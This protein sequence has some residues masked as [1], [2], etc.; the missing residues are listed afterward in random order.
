[1]STGTPSTNAIA[2]VKASNKFVVTGIP[3]Y[4]PAAAVTTTT[5]KELGLKLLRSH[6]QQKDGNGTNLGAVPVNNP[7]KGGDMGGAIIPTV[8][9]VTT[10][11]QTQLIQSSNSDSSSLGPQIRP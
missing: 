6:Y 1:V 11:K 10:S 5:T 3:D 4:V 8:I 7:E 2:L 9:G